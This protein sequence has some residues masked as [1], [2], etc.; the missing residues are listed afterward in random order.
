MEGERER[1]RCFAV[2]VYV[3]HTTTVRSS[4]LRVSIIQV[5]FMYCPLPPGNPHMQF[6]LKY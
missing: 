6:T 5:E 3:A 4:F 2:H 1:G